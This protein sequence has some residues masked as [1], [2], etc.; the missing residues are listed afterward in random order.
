MC[1]HASAERCG[2]SDRSRVLDLESQCG[3]CCWVESG[4]SDAAFGLSMCVADIVPVVDGRTKTVGVT[5]FEC[6]CLWVT[7]ER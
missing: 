3:V 4:R 7:E 2:A 5:Q 1:G 6:V